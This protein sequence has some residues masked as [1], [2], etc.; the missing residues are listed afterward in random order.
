MN[1]M[2]FRVYTNRW[3]N[4]TTYRISKTATGWHLRANAIYGDCDKEC[5]PFL[6]G[7]FDQDNMNYPSN[8]GAFMEHLWG[9]IDKGEIDAA[10]AQEKLQE[11]ADWVSACE[12]A[13][14]HW[15][16]WN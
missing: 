13:E 16:G 2:T 12:K 11:L 4:E 1:D 9:L 14:P 5:H 6:Y 3:K 7:N 8:I 15:P 10:E